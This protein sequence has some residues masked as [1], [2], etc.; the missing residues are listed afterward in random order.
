MSKRD[1]WLL[2]VTSA[3][4]MA[5][6]NAATADEITFALFTKNQTDPIFHELRVG[7]EKAAK[8]LGVNIIHYTPVKPN[9]L[10]E[11]TS[12]L[13][14]VAVRKPQAVIY[15]PVDQKA[16]APF[17]NRIAA[18]GVPVIN[19]LER[20]SE[21][22]YTIFVG[23]DDVALSYMAASFLLKTLG[24][25]GK[26]VILEGPRG[27][28]TT[29]D[30]LRGFMKAVN[31]R[32]EVKVLA[33]QPANHQRLQAL[34]VTENLIQRHAQIDG[35]LAMSDIMA[36]GALEALQA[37][38]RTEAKVVSVDGVAEAM[39]LIQ[40]GRLLGTAEFNGF[41]MG[42]LAVEA[43]ARHLKGERLPK[44]VLFEGRMITKDNFS[45][46]TKPV[47]ER[48]CPKLADYVAGN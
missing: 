46:F 32:P 25:K 19:V 9:N 29:A 28:A 23:Q 35:V 38:G 22:N 30:R 12:K 27:N 8:R 5:F 34:Q 7:A 44:D 16:E 18:S 47:A 17:V 11:Q 26:I 36:F 10:A 6:S 42:C 43:A 33:Q 40:Q 41:I 21:S 31:E 48:E 24:D 45:E 37:A 20:A 13:E 2:M 15:M 39:D 3:A 4:L 1:S 14:D